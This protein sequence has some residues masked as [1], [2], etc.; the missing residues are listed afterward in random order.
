MRDFL[1]CRGL[2]GVAVGVGTANRH[3]KEYPNLRGQAQRGY[4]LC[5]ADEPK[6]GEGTL[7]RGYP[8]T[9]FPPKFGAAVFNLGHLGSVW[10]GE[11]GHCGLLSLQ[12]RA[13]IA[14]A[15]CHHKGAWET[16]SSLAP[17][18]KVPGSWCYLCHLCYLCHNR[19]LISRVR[20][21]GEVTHCAFA[22]FRF[23]GF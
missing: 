4:F 8:G 23:Q 6:E 22:L 7:L 12:V 10:S 19:W 11:R 1:E 16:P 9:Q 18:R 5:H 15:Q 14:R 21:I 2:C 3:N 17:G 13:L 20:R